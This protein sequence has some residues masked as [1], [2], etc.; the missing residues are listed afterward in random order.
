METWTAVRGWFTRGPLLSQ[1]YC[2]T[3]FARQ[4]ARAITAPARTAPRH[5]RL[6]ATMFVANIVQW[7][8]SRYAMVSNAE[9]EKVVYDPQ[10]PTAT[11]SRHRGLAST[12]SVVHTRKKPRI[13]LPLMLITS[14]PQGN[15]ASLN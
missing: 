2:T 7:P 10:K 6:L 14:V 15:A 11:S 3:A 8:C 12:R 13:R 4:I 9:L 5:I 1:Q